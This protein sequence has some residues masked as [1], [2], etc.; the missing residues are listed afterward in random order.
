LDLLLQASLSLDEPRWATEVKRLSSAIID[1]IDKRGW[2]S[3]V[4]LGVESPGLMAGLAGIGYGLL[5]L[6]VPTHVP[7]VLMLE[8]PKTA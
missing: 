3:G 7:S 8:V 5:R 4:P 6:T 1:S 2:L